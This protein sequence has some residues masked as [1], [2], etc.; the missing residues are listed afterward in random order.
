MKR[1]II[2]IIFTISSF[3]ALSQ[4]NIRLNNYWGNAHYIN[5]AAIY[6]KYLAVFSMAARKQWIGLQGAPM[7][8]FASGSVY[9]DKLN[10]QLGIIAVQDKIGYSSISNINF[11]YGYA[12]QLENDWELHLGT[13]L[14]YQSLSF[15]IS[16]INVSSDYDPSL[17]QNLNL[18]NN[19]NADIGIEITSKSLRMGASSQNTFSIFTSENKKQVNTNFIYARYRQQSRDLV[20]LGVGV[21]GIQYANIYQAEFNVTGYFKMSQ[22]SGLTNKPDLFDLGL[23]FRTGSE[24]GVILGFDINESLH[25]SYSYDYNTGAIGRKSIGTNE[26]MLTLNL[27]RKTMCRNCWY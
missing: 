16:Q 5:P 10:T 21:C 4:S 13:G 2:I 25:L 11:T 8:Y 27:K 14:N 26:V 7:T 17:Y 6:D 15:D 1:S 12:I 22:T 19:F 3:I 20:N 9:L 18:E 24:I 23:F